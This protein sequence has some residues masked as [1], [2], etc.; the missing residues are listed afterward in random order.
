MVEE[1]TYI[2]AQRDAAR[3]LGFKRLYPINVDVYPEEEFNKLWECV[4]KADYAFEDTTR[5][6]RELFAAGML[7]AGTYNFEIPGEA[8]GQLTNAGPGSNAQIH[9]VTLAVNPTGMLVDAADDMFRFAFDKLGVHRISAMIPSFNHKV[10]RMA[11]LA[12][13]KFEGQI[14]SSF[15]YNSEWWDI[16]MYGLLEHEWKRRG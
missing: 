9:F 1:V 11:S 14:R 7:V 6:N 16:Q 15:L 2:E 10:V 3:K 4:S 13:M 8:F 12:K 5:G